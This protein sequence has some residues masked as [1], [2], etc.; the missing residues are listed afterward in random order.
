[1]KE[2]EKKNDQPFVVTKEPELKQFM[3][4]NCRKKITRALQKN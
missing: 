2:N 1:V 4:K 3:N